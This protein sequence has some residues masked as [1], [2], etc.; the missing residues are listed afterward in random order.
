M[1]RPT[2]SVSLYQQIGTGPAPHPA[3]AIA[4]CSTTQA[5]TSTCLPLEVGSPGPT[6]APEPVQVPCP[7]CGFANTF[8]GKTDEDGKVIEHYGRRCQGLFEDDE[9]NREEC[10]Y[11]LSRQDLPRLRR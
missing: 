5:T 2:E 4:W 11:P 6:P 9:G 3:R 8:W 1:L 7:A 10:D